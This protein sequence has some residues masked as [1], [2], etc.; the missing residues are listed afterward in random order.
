LALSLRVLVH[1]PAHEVWPVGHLPTCTG[2]WVLFA[3]QPTAKR[4]IEARSDR[5]LGMAFSKAAARGTKQP[6][7]QFD[8][9]RP[10]RAE[11]ERAIG[12]P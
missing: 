4:T 1:L 2:D 5:A 7:G 11:N 12:A 9:P 3:P 6:L 10:A 8:R